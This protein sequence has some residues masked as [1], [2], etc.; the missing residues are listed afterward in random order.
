MCSNSFD[1]LSSLLEN[2]QNQ[3]KCNYC[4]NSNVTFFAYVPHKS[5]GVKKLRCSMHNDLTTSGLIQ[6]F[7]ISPYV[8]YYKSNFKDNTKFFRKLWPVCTAF[9]FVSSK[10]LH[11]YHLM[12]NVLQL[13]IHNCQ[14]WSISV[15]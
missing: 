13:K 7:L 15:A 10:A 11:V 5:Y 14:F 1:F 12:E 2:I 3:E 8:Q 6:S 9:F 4:E